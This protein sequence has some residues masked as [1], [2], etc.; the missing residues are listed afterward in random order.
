[1]VPGQCALIHADKAFDGEGRL[2]DERAKKSAR[3]LVA[4]LAR[5]AALPSG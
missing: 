1:V 2:T 5:A 3:S 4:A